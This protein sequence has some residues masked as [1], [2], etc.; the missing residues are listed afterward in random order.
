MSIQ[1]ALATAL[2][3]LQV[4]Q[5]QANLIANNVA[6]A[7]T[8]GYVR[9]TLP[10]SEL[11]TGGVGAGVVAGAIQRLGDS[12]LAASANQAGGA[13]A[14]SQ[15]MVDVLTTYTQAVGQ[16]G[17]QGTLPSAISA[18]QS[19]LTTLSATPSDSVAQ[20]AAV[21]AAQ[22]VVAALHGLDAA[23]AGARQQADAGIASDVGS[24]NATLDQLARNQAG[25]QNAAAR[26]ES[27]AS[28]QDTQ[29]SLIASLSQKLPVKTFNGPNDSLIVTTDGGTTLFDGSAAHHLAF[30]ASSGLPASAGIGGTPGQVTVDGQPLQISQSGSIAANL[31]LRDTT[32]P[33][34][35][36][37][38]DQLAGN[39]I[40]A[41]QSA[42]PTV[43]AAAPAGLFTNAGQALPAGGTAAPGLAG[44]IALNAAVDP[45]QGGASWRM[46]DGVNAGAQGQATDNATVLAFVQALGAAGSYT[47]GSGLPASASI[48]DAGTELAGLQQGAL[49]QWTATN[50]ARGTQAQDAQTAL[51]SQTGVNIDTEMQ[52]LL[53]VQQ[54]YSASAQVIQVANQMLSTILMTTQAAAQV[55]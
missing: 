18:F 11:V 33:G 24:V 53:V 28:F 7:S 14:Y 35:A 38:L 41:F 4:E 54:A 8:P 34:F 51:S 27:T 40:A 22:N 25:L 37:Q 9:R 36:S 17:E 2:S 29:A 42:D 32:L 19:A 52:R 44:S 26:G 47:T 10:Q 30:A 45:T 31:T 12:M 23:A 20:G 43:S 46:R 3:G 15:R 50:T 6:N 13:Q 5:Q 49:S 21:T 1:G 39:L 16:P 48:A 55:A